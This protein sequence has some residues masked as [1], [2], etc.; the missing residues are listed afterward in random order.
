[1]RRTNLFL[2]VAVATSLTLANG[3]STIGADRKQASKELVEKKK[4][5]E[6]LKADAIA[7]VAVVGDETDERK[8]ADATAKAASSL[9]AARDAW[10][11]VLA[12]FSEEWQSYPKF[13]DRKTNPDQYQARARAEI[14]YIQAQLELA[15]CSYHESQ[16]TDSD[17][18][19]NEALQRAA[20]QYEQ[21]HQ[22]YRSMVAGLAARVWQARCYQEQDD[23]RAA[24]GIVNE[25]VAHA[26]RVAVLQKLQD[27]ARQIRL[28]CLN[29]PKR[30]DYQV[31]ISEAKK[32]IIDVSDEREAA[33]SGQGI[34]WELA[35]A[36]E[37]HAR[38]A[39]TP[40]EER[41]PLLAEALAIARSLKK[42]KGP[43]QKLAA[44]KAKELE[45][46]L[47]PGGF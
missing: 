3:T 24:L 14:A 27:Q 37:L 18:T 20:K 15:N 21:I 42:T 13:I 45:K 30:R 2:A 23:I 34:R 19:R 10:T 6:Q 28:A 11:E 1:M 36:C 35:R 39:S 5:A 31:V 32:W 47:A 16:I 8:Q 44:S 9:T 4:K 40:D 17:K 38:H 22:K 26:G 33:Q 7:L 41:G 29:H 43:F 12:L 25:L 46:Q